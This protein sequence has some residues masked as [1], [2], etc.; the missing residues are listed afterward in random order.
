MSTA[1]RLGLLYGAAF[2]AIGAAMP[3]LPVLYRQHGLSGAEIGVVLA[4]PLLARLVTGPVIA[5][6]A[7]RFA[8]RRTPAAILLLIAAVA[9]A[10]V[11]LAGGFWGFLI[12]GFVWGT[13]QPAAVPLID[14]M[15]LRRAR[16]EGFDYGWP[17][18]LGSVGYIGANLGWGALLIP[19]G[20]GAVPWWAA[21]CLLAGA[22]V[23]LW[24]VPPE[25]THAE[26]QTG[27]VRRFD[28][29][30]ELA[31][32]RLFLLTIASAGAAQASHGFYYGFSTLVWTGGGVPASLVG[33]LW[34]VGVAV[35][36]AF[37]WFAAR[38]RT[39]LGP[40]RLL[41]LGCAAGVVRW[42]ALAAEPPLWL[43]IPLQGLHSLTFTAT[44]M[45]SLQMIER[46]TP[47]RH[48]S[49]AQTASS[50]A[51]ASLMGLATLASGPLFDRFGAGG[52]L[53]MGLMSAAGLAGAVLLFTRSPQPQS[54]GVGGSTTEPT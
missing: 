51:T 2:A 29:V 33:L 15:T 36:V 22:A 47:A 53:A 46:L 37:F 45:A 27:P 35:E 32:N 14:V 49:L 54:S 40:E 24:L 10:A 43:L 13:A 19:L 41:L 7:D 18:G 52:Y 44:F 23:A 1:V 39:R 4:A 25:P 31:R 48:A 17:R 42:A 26:P 30:G 12:A 11:P 38:L 50:A 21:G 8:R 6:W 34:G 3:Y 16:R 28:G 9:F 20:A 5:L